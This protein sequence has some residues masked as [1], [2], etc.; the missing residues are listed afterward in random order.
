MCYR[1]LLYKKK[2]QPLY[3]LHN[4][5]SV[6]EKHL[7]VSL[8]LQGCCMAVQNICNLELIKGSIIILYFYFTSDTTDGSQIIFKD[9]SF[10]LLY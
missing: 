7:S 8:S 10:K 3:Q 4:T 2:N 5:L 1:A 6:Y 9:A